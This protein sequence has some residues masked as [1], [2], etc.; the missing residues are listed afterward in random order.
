[1]ATS[2]RAPVHLWIVGILALLW[3][4]FGAFDYVMSQTQNAAY[5]AQFSDADRLY[6][7]S[8]PAWA[9][10]GW[11]LGVW[12]GLVGSLLLLARSRHAE[13]AFGLSLLGLLVATIY[14]HVLS[15]MPADLKTGPMVAMNVAI[16]AVA[17]GLFVY[18]H[19]MRARGIL[20]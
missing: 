9:V 6:F 5:L 12:G 18:A 13:F 20:R 15:A 11:A 16:W 3:N 17:I 10:A 1:M 14:Q 19:R 4:A 2:A 7:N 8:F